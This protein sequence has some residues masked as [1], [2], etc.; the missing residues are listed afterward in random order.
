[1]P[2]GGSARRVL[3]VAAVT[4][5]EALRRRIVL[6]AL[7]MSLGFLALYG[8]A[9]HFAATDLLGQGGGATGI[10]RAAGAAQLMYVGLFAASFLIA[11]TAVFAS[12]GA[13]SGELDSG[14]IY[15]VLARPIRR[16]ELVLG[17]ALGLAVMLVAYALALDGA[18]IALAHG[19]IGSPLSSWPA[20]M[21]LFALEPLVLTAI[22][23]LGSSRLP[24]LANGVLCTAAYGI[25]FVGGFVEQIGGL[26]GNRTMV[27]LGIVSSLLMPLDAVHRMA[28][29]SVMPNGLLFGPAAAGIG[30]G[31]STTP[32]V[33]MLAYAVGYVLLFVWLAARSFR[34]RDL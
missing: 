15:G 11:L 7:V 6:A 28:L 27:S 24:T 18:V 1:M 17:R 9:L 29:S 32:S 31:E 25:G 8:L 19:I 4:A 2:S 3:A 16:G 34:S 26:L 12:V 10:V 20:A 30:L 33:W 22:A 21:P 23:L 13:I 14:V 5:R